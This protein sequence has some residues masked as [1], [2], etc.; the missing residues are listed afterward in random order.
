[1]TVECNFK[2]AADRG[3]VDE[4]ERRPL[5]VTETPQHGLRQPEVVVARLPVPP[6]EVQV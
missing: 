4:R 5:A 6:R 1:M 3:A 2:Y